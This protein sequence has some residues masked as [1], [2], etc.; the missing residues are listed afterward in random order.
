VAQLAAQGMTNR[1]VAQALFVTVKAVQWHLRNVYRK[2][3]ASSREE[4]PARLEGSQ[5]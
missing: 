4:L 5:D 3:G 2:L 1:E